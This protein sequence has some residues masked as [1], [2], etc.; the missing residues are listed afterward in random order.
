MGCGLLPGLPIGHKIQTK[1]TR[2]IDWHASAVNDQ[3]IDLFLSD[4]EDSLTEM[5]PEL[6]RYN[7]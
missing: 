6:S 2:V 5:V 3:L 1:V 4:M 7:Y